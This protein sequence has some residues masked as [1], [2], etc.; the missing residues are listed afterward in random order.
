MLVTKL[1]F[2]GL[3]SDAKRKAD[4]SGM[5]VDRHHFIAIQESVRIYQLQASIFKPVI[6]GSHSELP[7]LNATT[8]VG[9][10]RFANI[11][12]MR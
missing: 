12:S 7:R 6:T 8:R 1:T 9:M 3:A 11:G 10:R 2:H 4:G 5:A